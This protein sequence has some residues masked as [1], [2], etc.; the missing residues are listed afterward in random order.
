MYGD[1]AIDY[2]TVTRWVKRIIDGQEEPAES[3]ICDRPRSV[4]PSSAYSSANI[5][6]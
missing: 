6:H 1:D 5:D 4:R 3:D 2:N